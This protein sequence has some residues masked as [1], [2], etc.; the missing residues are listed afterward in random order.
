VTYLLDISTLIAVLWETH[1]LHDRAA[2]WI[3]GKKLAV[4]PIT[5]L[6]F[7]RVSV[8]A[9]GADL[10]KAREMLKSFLEKYKPAFVPCDLPALDGK[11]A[12]TAGKTTD[13][14]LLNLAQKHGMNWATLDEHVKHPAAFLLPD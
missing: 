2:K 3:G 5:E 6:G 14:Y 9:H 11:S 4:C 8:Y 7:L 12:P 10:D 1:V 13:F